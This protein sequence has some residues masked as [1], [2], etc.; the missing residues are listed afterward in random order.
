VC[1]CLV[2]TGE[3]TNKEIPEVATN[4]PRIKESRLQKV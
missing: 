4:D 2:L 3:P 1:T